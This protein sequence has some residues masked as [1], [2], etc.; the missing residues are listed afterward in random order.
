[1]SID[2]SDYIDQDSKQQ[3]PLTEKKTT[4]YEIPPEGP[5]GLRF[6]G[7][8]EMGKSVDNSFGDEKIVD[9]VKLIFEVSG[10]NYPVRE[11]NGVKF[12]FRVTVTENKSMFEKSNLFKIF[13]K[14]RNGN[15][16]IKHIAQMLGQAFSGRLYHYKTKKNGNTI[17]ILRSVSVDKDGKLTTGEYNISPPYFENPQTGETIKVDIPEPIS[18]QRCFL[19][20]VADKKMWDSIFIEGPPERNTFQNDIRK[21]V[22][23]Q[24]IA[25]KIG[26]EPLTELDNFFEEVLEKP[27]PVRKDPQHDYAKRFTRTK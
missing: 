19:W 15:A 8:I 10:K 22:N 9:R 18:T 23:F 21:A 11:V 26:E 5:C 20:N 13:N 2:Y 27:E 3:K 24:E 25:K 4:T 7:Y 16:N 17:C 14:M 12:P 6:I 1:M